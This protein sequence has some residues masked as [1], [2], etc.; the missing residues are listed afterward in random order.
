MGSLKIVFSLDEVSLDENFLI[1][2]PIYDG[3]NER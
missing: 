1:D 2:F 3:G